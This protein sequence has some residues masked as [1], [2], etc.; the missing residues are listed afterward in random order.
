VDALQGKLQRLVGSVVKVTKRS[1]PAADAERLE[2]P[3]YFECELQFN[4]S[5][6]SATIFTSRVP[7]DWLKT[8]ALHEPATA[9][10]LFMKRLAKDPAAHTL[11]LAKEIA[12]HPGVA[13]KRSDNDDLFRDS[14]D[15]LLGKSVLGALAMD[16]GLLDNVESRGRIRAEENL[17]FYQMMRAATLV[18][19]NTLVRI[20]KD[21][22]PAIQR[23]WEDRAQVKHSEQD[24]ALA[25]EVVRRATT[26]SYS[27]ALLFND[28]K[29]QIG[30]LFTFDGV[31]RR[32]VRV[33]AG[34]AASGDGGPGRAANHYGI[35]HYYELEVF[36]D[37]SQNYPLIFCVADLPP[38]FPTGANIHVP[39]RVAGFFFKNWLYSTRGRNQA[40][41][42]SDGKPVG[43]QAQFAPLLL[44]RSP[45][46]LQPAQPASAHVG[47]FVLGGLF[48][49]ALAGVWIAAVWFAR[50]DRRF[51]QRTL[52]AGF[53]L[54]P[55][56]SLNDLNVPTVEEPMIIEAIPP[57]S[58]GSN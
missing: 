5:N 12:W 47:R 50:D 25:R 51:R 26:G 39:V 29:P 1:P 43:P 38:D 19:P 21:N 22:L 52:A 58:A 44:G 53:E 14:R 20:A 9:N 49:L 6:D 27:A 28:P 23:E 10:A 46:V 15:S 16:V 37:D 36:T 45:I 7:K 31:A 57:H 42:T 34:S 8:G 54:P 24:Q 30:R 40:D 56:Q 17:A 2:M 13:E 11:W 18:K 55:G 4:D 33:E 3:E 35:P 32:A 48:L 41:E